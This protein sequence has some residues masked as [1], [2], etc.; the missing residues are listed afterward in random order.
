MIALADLD[1]NIAAAKHA[2]ETVHQIVMA[3]KTQVAAFREANADLE[4]G[5]R[6][7]IGYRRTENIWLV[8]SHVG[9]CRERKAQ[10]PDAG[11]GNFRPIPDKG[12][13]TAWWQERKITLRLWIEDC[14]LRI[15][16]S[17]FAICNLQSTI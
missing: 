15:C 4:P 5:K 9:F 16:K 7:R 14:R 1:G 2:L 17:S 11:P 6:A 10:G 12:T 8:K 3:E 13:L